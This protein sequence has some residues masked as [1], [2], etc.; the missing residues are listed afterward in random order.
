VDDLSGSNALLTGAAGGLGRHIARALAAR[1]VR[2]ALSG[3][4]AAP[5][6]ELCGEL[7]RRGARA[8]PVLADLSDLAQAA[9]LVEQAEAA[10]GPID[11]LVSNAGLEL[12]AAYP[13]FTDDELAAITRVNLV[14]PMVLA[15]HALP[16]M[17]ARERGHIVTVSSLAGRGGNAYNVLY[18]T[19]KAGLVGFTRS[20]RAELDGTPVGAGVICPG[21]I[22]G[23]GMYARMRELGVDAP[24]APRGGARDGRERRR[25]GDRP[26]SCR[27]ARHRLADAPAAG[28]PGARAVCG[29]AGHQRDR[30][31]P[32]LRHAGA[33]VRTRLGLSPGALGRRARGAGG[34]DSWVRV[35]RGG[36][37]LSDEQHAVGLLDALARERPPGHDPDVGPRHAADVRPRR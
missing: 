23:D 14:A 15:R 34:R 31:E 13:A 3:R 24:A 35:L 1:G 18:A 17:L 33:A 30:R 7:R 32:V 25:R 4:Q 27:H 36:N 6:D 9:V 8:E 11:L 2:L 10:I 21:F 26:R 16:G 12:P 29:R 22:A 19:T 28:R 5:L 37:H 20:L